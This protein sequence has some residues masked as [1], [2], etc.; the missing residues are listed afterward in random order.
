MKSLTFDILIWVRRGEFKKTKKH[1]GFDQTDGT[2][3]MKPADMKLSMASAGTL[4]SL[5]SHWSSGTH[6]TWS[7]TNWT[8]AR[9]ILK[10]TLCFSVSIRVQSKFCTTRGSVKLAQRTLQLAGLLSSVYLTDSQ[11]NSIS[12]AAVQHRGERVLKEGRFLLGSFAGGP[13]LLFSFFFFLFK[14]LTA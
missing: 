11:D 13:L 4:L 5:A 14:A 8:R 2:D 7:S 10:V 3:L 1:A 6:S 12:S 9:Q